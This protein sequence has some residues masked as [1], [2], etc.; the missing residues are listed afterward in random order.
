MKER[1][2]ICS[3]PTVRAILKGDKTQMRMVVK[4]TPNFVHWNPIVLNEQGGWVDEHGSPIKPQYGN[5]GDRLWVRETF[6]RFGDMI[7]YKASIPQDQKVECKWKPSVHM[8]RVA[9][10]ILLEITDVRVE[11]LQEISEEDAKAEGASRCYEA[12]EGNFLEPD[13][14]TDLILGPTGSHYT[15]FKSAW[16]SIHSQESW[17]A[18]PWVWAVDFKRIEP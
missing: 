2:I 13:K 1:P 5:P 10:R 8:P 18:N 7:F 16:Y 6:Y 12:I 4:G 3:T 15:G 17:D 9:S 14:K 11:R